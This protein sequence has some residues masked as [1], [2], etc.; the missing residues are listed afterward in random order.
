MNAWLTPQPSL[1]EVNDVLFSFKSGKT[2]GLDG[3][4]AAFFK[5]FWPD[6]NVVH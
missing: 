4:S 6:L 2:L 5:Q 3:V 1:E